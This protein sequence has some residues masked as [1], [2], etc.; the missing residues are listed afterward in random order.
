MSTVPL[1]NICA[2]IWNKKLISQKN[3]LQKRI[4]IE[5]V[6]ISGKIRGRTLEIGSD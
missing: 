6:L 1:L 3:K 4:P 5:R 2:E